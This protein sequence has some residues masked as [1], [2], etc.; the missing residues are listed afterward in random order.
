MVDLGG[1]LEETFRISTPLPGATGA[2]G[3]GDEDED[4][5]SHESHE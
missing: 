3:A 2:T 5:S 4:A 1:W